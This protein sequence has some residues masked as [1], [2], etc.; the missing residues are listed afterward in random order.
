MLYKLAEDIKE[1]ED[2][3]K[4]GEGSE[5]FGVAEICETEEGEVVQGE[6]G[7][8]VSRHWEEVGDERAWTSA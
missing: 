2:R 6:D 8:Q 4:G 1:D 7:S 5:E 3:W